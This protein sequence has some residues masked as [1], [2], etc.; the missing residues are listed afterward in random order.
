[1][2]GGMRVLGAVIVVAL[3]AGVARAQDVRY[4]LSPVLDRGALTA[5]DVEMVLR[6]EGDGVTEIEL[7]DAWGGKSDLW[8]G[9]SEFR[10]SGEGLRATAG[11]RPSLKTIHHAP[12]AVLTVRYRVTQIW[13]G[14]PQ[15]G[16]SNEYR[17]VVRP[18]YFHL[19][20]WTTLARPNWSLATPVKVSF[21][22]FP[23]D[24]AFASNLEHAPKRG[25]SLVD[26]L[27]SVSVGGDFRV[28]SAGALRVAVRGAWSFADGDFIKRLEPII[29]AHHKFWGDPP[30]PF[31]VTVLPLESPAGRM[32]LGGTAL[33]SAFAFMA[34]DNV[35]DMQLT[36]IL[37]HE[38]LHS[39]IPRRLGTMPQ[40]NDAVDYWFSEGFTDFYT[41]RIL[42][43]DGLWPV[44]DGA[45]AFNDVLWNY[46]FSPVRNATNAR[47][48]EAFWR[49]RAMG[50]MPY[51]RGFVFAALADDRVRRATRGERDLDDIVLAMKR[52]ADAVNEGTMAPPVRDLFVGAMRS[53][54][55]DVAADIARY[56]EKGETILLPGDVWAP[57]GAVVTSEVPEFARGFDGS[58]TIANGNA[59]T[60]VDSAGPAFAAG[61]RDGMRILRL[62]LSEGGDA[63]V[64]LAYTVFADG[65][66][67]EISYLPA[68]KKRVVLQELKLRELPDEASRKACAAR[69]G[70]TG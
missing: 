64:R 47:V 58:R 33:R 45:K 34:T 55:V 43:R 61:L 2:G 51:Q 44:E 31:L 65:E 23:A 19:I 29:A 48:A 46:A 7:P 26:A 16:V 14:E 22:G 68:G 8:R 60:G 53:F 10:V 37:A 50:D 11:A 15:A 54:G 59:V 69:L 1:M 36:R 62:D 17:P 5:I 49:E 40:Q 38:H 28:L 56:I 18:T 3:A 70:G 57:C 67:R 24:W 21:K 4:A 41:D 63:R 30:E 66:T 20:G 32:S 9:I 35:E 52:A 27:E 13:Q 12:G 42:V 25:L 6:G 39:W